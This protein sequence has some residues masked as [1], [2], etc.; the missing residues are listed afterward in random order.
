MAQ[1]ELTHPDLP[2]VTVYLLKVTPELATEMLKRN[3]EGQR[4]ISK[5]AVERYAADMETE[6]W[7]FNGAPVIMS[8]EHRLLDGQHRLSAIIESGQAQLLLVI[9][10]L[11]AGAMST[12]DAGRTRSYADI[13][14]IRGVPH[15]A[16]VAA[17]TAKVWQWFHGNYGI[18]KTARVANPLHLGGAPSHA[19]R[20]F[21]LRKIEEAYDITFVHAAK[22]AASAYSKR[23]GISIST[24]GLAWIILSGIDKSLR[25]SYFEDLLNT[26]PNYKRSSQC[27]VLHNRLNRIRANEDFDAVDQ[28]DAL[29][30]SYNAW[31]NGHN[32]TTISPPRP[33]RFNVLE[34]PKDYVELAK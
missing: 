2:N 15:H 19:Q 7:I 10:G 32:L 1:A 5:L 14:K 6:D 16:N 9:H 27:E 29:F 21:W 18:G 24:Y 23:R 30:T 12:I 17:L 28:L 4:T 13:L 26:D 25:D 3:S 22:F 34:I 8:K 11:D 20:D 31:V 33:V